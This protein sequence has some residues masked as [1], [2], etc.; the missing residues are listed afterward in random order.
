[1]DWLNANYPQAKKIDDYGMYG[2]EFP[3]EVIAYVH[4]YWNRV[5]D[6]YVKPDPVV[7]G[8]VDHMFQKEVI[9]NLKVIT[10]EEAESRK[11][12]KRLADPE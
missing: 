10:P 5:G 3:P 6:T 9:T 1:M 8:Y 4:D 11:N 12:V 7:G 2:R